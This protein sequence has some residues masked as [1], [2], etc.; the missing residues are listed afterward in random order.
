MPA[1]TPHTAQADLAKEIN[2][3]LTRLQELVAAG[4]L[5][6]AID[7][8]TECVRSNGVIQAF[9]TGHSEGFSMEIAGRAGG[10]IPTRRITLREVVLVGGRDREDL[11][12]PE[13]ER[14]PTV[15]E[16]LLAHTEIHPQ[17]VFIIA[18]NSGVNS[19]I[20]GMALA[21]KERG[22][23]VI[24]VTSLEH[25]RAVEP[26]HASG[27]RLSEIADVVID[28]LAPFGDATLE[29]AEGIKVGAV[30][31]LTATYI[32]QALTVGVVS[33]MVEAGEVPPVFLSANIPGGDEHNR[34][35]QDLYGS[36]IKSF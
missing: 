31:S 5:Q 21:L 32:G 23:Q 13:L 18:S 16:E 27:K 25:T 14:D 35:L 4:G 30:S 33:K 10:L 24:A 6:G 2:S 11:F 20:V 8:L 9:G 7:L 1:S 34:V 17:D 28:N 22:H 19:S 3:R 12:K 26:K 15:V 36:R 29:L